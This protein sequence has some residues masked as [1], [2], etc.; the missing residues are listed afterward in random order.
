MGKLF[1]DGSKDPETG[2]TWTAVYIPQYEIA[3]IKRTTNNLSVYTVELMGVLIA[4]NWIQENNVNNA[5]IATDSW[6]AL[7]RIKTMKSCR[8]DVINEIH[9]NIF[10][11]HEKGLNV[12][13]VW[14]PAHVGVEENVDKLAKLSLKWQT[15]DLNVPLSRAEGNSIIKSQ[16]ME[17][18]QQFWDVNDTGRHLYNIQEKFG[19]GR[20][21]GRN[22]K[23][24]FS[25]SLE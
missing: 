4:L 10:C 17:K 19:V 12:G 3:I 15:V 16:M 9:W 2:L 20:M 8:L 24:F 25:L 7:L 18:W 21:R 13:F 23:Y 1:S 6:S 11:L 5:T 14:V 22:R